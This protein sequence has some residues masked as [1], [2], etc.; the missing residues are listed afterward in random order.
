MF[1]GLLSAFFSWLFLRVLIPQ[2][3]LRLID[4]PNNRSSHLQPTPRGGGIVFVTVSLLFS[5]LSLLKGD[6]GSLVVLPLFSAP[7]ALVGLF[8]DHNLPA[9]LRYVFQL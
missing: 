9:S 3:R 2:L 4:T 8:D 7:L 5:F 6:G 1:I